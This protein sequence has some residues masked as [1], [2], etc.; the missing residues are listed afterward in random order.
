MRLHMKGQRS[1]K[2]DHRHRSDE[3]GEPPDPGGIVTLR[4]RLRKRRNSEDENDNYYRNNGKNCG[5]KQV[6]LGRSRIGR[7]GCCAHELI[8]HLCRKFPAG[9][10][11][12]F[13]LLTWNRARQPCGRYPND[14]RKRNSTA[15]ANATKL[16]NSKAALPYSR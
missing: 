11:F 2:N 16:P 3:S 7:S 4:P 8:T 10:F 6:L 1:Q 5:K 13:F 12:E 14:G 15:G 9:T